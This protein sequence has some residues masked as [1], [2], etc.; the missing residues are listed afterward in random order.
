MKLDSSL[1]LIA[2][3]VAMD[4]RHS[5]SNP[6]LTKKGAS[7]GAWEV[8]LLSEALCWDLELGTTL[9]MELICM[10]KNSEE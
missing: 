8:Q 10:L 1:H 9:D 3:Y 6:S 5:S 7:S 2:M 4:T